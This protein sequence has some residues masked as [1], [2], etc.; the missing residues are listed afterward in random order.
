MFGSRKV[1]SEVDLL[2]EKVK[3]L[4]NIIDFLS[5]R[6]L[7]K[8]KSEIQELSQEWEK[9][10]EVFHAKAGKKIDATL[11][12]ALR[13][14]D[15]LINDESFKKID[16]L[17]KKIP[18]AT[19]DDIVRLEDKLGQISI[20]GEVVEGLKSLSSFVHMFNKSQS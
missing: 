8:N 20:S 11:Q 1:Q 13:E 14:D 19:K 3:R 12:S 6:N 4:E 15:V 16:S 17:L 2:K 9:E 7:N 5:A 18:F 10:E